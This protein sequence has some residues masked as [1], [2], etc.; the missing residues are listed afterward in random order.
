MNNKT[1]EGNDINIA[2]VDAAEGTAYLA[3]R[4]GFVYLHTAF[5]IIINIAKSFRL[6]K[7]PNALPTGGGS[8][9]AGVRAA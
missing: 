5:K 8:V 7:P 9:A 4:T 2:K 1:F 3:Y 6:I